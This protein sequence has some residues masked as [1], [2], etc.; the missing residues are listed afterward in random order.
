M[1]KHVENVAESMLFREAEKVFS[2]PEK[3]YLL[4]S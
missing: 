4:N 1:L 2:H 3:A